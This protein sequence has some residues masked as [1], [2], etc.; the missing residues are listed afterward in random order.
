VNIQQF[1]VQLVV[2]QYIKKIILYGVNIVDMKRRMIKISESSEDILLRVYK[3][4]NS[5]LFNVES[6]NNQLQKKLE[7]NNKIIKQTDDLLETVYDELQRMAKEKNLE[8][9]IPLPRN[10]VEK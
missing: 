9:V 6:E 1:R 10:R 2:C 7:E 4:L 3:D 8:L 5:Y